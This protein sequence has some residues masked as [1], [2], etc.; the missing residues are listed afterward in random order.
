MKKKDKMKKELVQMYVSAVVNRQVAYKEFRDYKYELAKKNLKPDSALADKD[1]QCSMLE[2]KV[3][4]LKAALRK[5]YSKYEVKLFT[6]AAILHYMYAYENGEFDESPDCDD[7]GDDTEDDET[8]SCGDDDKSS[9]DSTSQALYGRR[10]EETKRAEK[11]YE[12]S[13]RSNKVNVL[14]DA[15]E[16]NVD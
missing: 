15:V 14:Q 16:L 6:D 13:K 4:G 9:I 12:K 5:C 7:D 3:E 1:K 11:A 10:Y 8:E 2:G